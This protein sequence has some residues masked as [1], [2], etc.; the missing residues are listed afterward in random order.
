VQI[1]SG[2]YVFRDAEA[3]ANT[4]I[5]I[6]RNI[7]DDDHR[8]LGILL[9]EMDTSILKDICATLPLRDSGSLAIVNNDNYVLF[10]TNPTKIGSVLRLPESNDIQFHDGVYVSQGM[11]NDE[12]ALILRLPFQYSNLKAIAILPESSIGS[13]LPFI[14]FFIVAVTLAMLALL[15]YVS[16]AVSKGVLAPIIALTHHMD[17]M[18]YGEFPQYRAK[19]RLDEIGRL[20]QG[21]QDMSVRLQELVDMEYKARIRE[22]KARLLTLQAHINPHFLYNT[23]ESISMTALI[24]N[25]MQVVNQ[26]EALGDIL[27]ASIDTEEWT[28]PLEKEVDHIRNYLFLV[29]SSDESRFQVVWNIDENALSYKTNRLILQPIV[30]NAIKHGFAN[31]TS[32]GVIKISIQKGEKDISIS[33]SD[34]GCGMP[35]ERM[36]Q[37]NLRFRINDSDLAYNKKIG[38]HNVNSR[39]KMY[40]GA[41]YGLYLKEAEDGGLCVQITIPQIA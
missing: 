32:G 5:G 18:G 20:E 33:V 11:V 19:P 24:N 2:Y 28:I 26:I 35:K 10:H 36:E 3:Q 12:N 13:N 23:L 21:F 14:K 31:L 9:R 40:Y 1:I 41:Q 15:L 30:E 17:G 29:S 6:A 25:D 37:F 4:V 22:M 39:L 16:F 38:L 34:N 8:W 27:R 7:Y